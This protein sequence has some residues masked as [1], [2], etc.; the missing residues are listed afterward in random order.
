[1]SYQDAVV[2]ESPIGLWPLNAYYVGQDISIG[3]KLN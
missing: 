2:R 3:K 1:M